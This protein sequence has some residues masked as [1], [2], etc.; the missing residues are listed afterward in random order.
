MT[1]EEKVYVSI[2]TWLACN[3]VYGH[4]YVPI[5]ELA[6]YDPKFQSFTYKNTGILRCE[7]CGHEVKM[8]CHDCKKEMVS[9]YVDCGYQVC[10]DCYIERNPDYNDYFEWEKP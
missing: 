9:N 4:C 1:G 6:N 8:K 7:N 2:W 3:F 10:R 5:K